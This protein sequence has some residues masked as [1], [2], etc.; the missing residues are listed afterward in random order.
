MV[1]PKRKSPRRNMKPSY[2][3]FPKLM[4]TRPVLAKRRLS[5]AG[6]M[7]CMC[8]PEQKFR[9]RSSANAN[10]RR[11]AA[12][13]LLR[14][15]SSHRVSTATGKKNGTHPHSAVLVVRTS[16]QRRSETP[17]EIATSNIQWPQ[18]RFLHASTIIRAPQPTSH[19]EGAHTSSSLVVTPPGH[20]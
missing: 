3:A 2:L 12:H 17:L 19:K 14:R 15:S 7:I 11:R 1:S 16:E 9:P 4:P 20:S 6:R 8:K 10:P 18:S 13:L 5:A